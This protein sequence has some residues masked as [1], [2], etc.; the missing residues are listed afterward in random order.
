M[1]ARS[2]MI[3]ILL[4]LLLAGCMQQQ[5]DASELSETDNQGNT[6]QEANTTEPETKKQ[7]DSVGDVDNLESNISQ[8]ENLIKDLE[9]TEEINFN[10]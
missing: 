3:V 7:E 9:E 8:V 4:A 10:I 5:K 6:P 2:L 1:K